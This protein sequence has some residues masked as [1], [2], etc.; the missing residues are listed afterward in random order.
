MYVS[1]PG[2]VGSTPKGPG[3]GVERRRGASRDSR[4]VY[5]VILERTTARPLGNGVA[6]NWLPA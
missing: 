1:Q 5:R 3:C 2:S 4:A 6:W